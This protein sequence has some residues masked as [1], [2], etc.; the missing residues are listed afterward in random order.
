MYYVYLIQNEDHVIYYGSTNDLRRRMVEHQSGKSFSTKGHIW[1]LIYYEAYFD[2][3]DA[4]E[5]EKQ[6]K[7][8]GQA[9]AQLKRRLKNSL[10]K[11]KIS[12]GCI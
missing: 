7:Y 5:R 1:R 9:L 4:R 2:E 6:L 12:A 11:T 8:H 10:Q 3:H